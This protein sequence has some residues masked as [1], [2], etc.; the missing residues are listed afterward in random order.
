VAGRPDFGF[1][2]T[3]TLTLM[4]LIIGFSFSMAVNRYDQRKNLEEA[5]ANAIGTEYKRA[6]LL[7]AADAARVRA[8]L[9]QYFDQ[10]LLFYTARHA[11]QVQEINART[12]EL[13]D[14]LWSVVVAPASSS[15]QPAVMLAVSGMNDVLNSQGYTQASWWNRIPTG[16]W[17]LMISIAAAS[18]LLLGIG[19]HQAQ[20]EH[21]LTPVLP[22]VLSFAFFFI[23]DIDSPR[24]GVIRVH[25]DNLSSI[26][27]M[28][29]AR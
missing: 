7:P 2:V 22:L 15:L 17:T 20:G 3:A 10:R 12:A 5:E 14:Q 28:F 27:P 8:L 1:V 16:A 25:P 19:V 9:K 26:A 6:D 11:G 4:G 13:Q 21:K 23:A 29:E 18:C 24:S